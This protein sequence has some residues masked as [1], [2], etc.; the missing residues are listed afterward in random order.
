MAKVPSIRRWRERELDPW[1]DWN[2]MMRDVFKSGFMTAP[3]EEAMGVNVPRIDLSESETDYEL[4][5]ELPGIKRDEIDVTVQGNVVTLKG[6][7]HERKEDKDRNYHRIE[8]RYGSFMRSVRLPGEVDRERTTATFE[9]GVLMVTLPKT[10]EEKL[11]ARKI[12]VK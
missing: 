3:D 8:R 11:S 1:R 2:T 5:C 4:S 10:H 7:K 6:E 9:D 12:R